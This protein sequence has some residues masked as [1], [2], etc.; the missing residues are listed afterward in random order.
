[1]ETERQDSNSSL[2][3]LY[4]EYQE[5][6]GAKGETAIARNSSTSSTSSSSSRLDS[7]HIKD[8]SDI[9]HESHSPVGKAYSL[10][11]FSMDYSSGPPRYTRTSIAKDSSTSG[12]A[13]SLNLFAS[14][15]SAISPTPTPEKSKDS[16]SSHSRHVNKSPKV[17]IQHLLDEYIPNRWNS[18]TSPRLTNIPEES[19]MPRTKTL[20]CIPR[21]PTPSV[22]LY[23]TSSA[24]C[25]FSV[26][27]EVSSMKGT[28]VNDD[29][30]TISVI[31]TVSPVS[32]RTKANTTR[33]KSPQLLEMY[34][35]SNTPRMAPLELGQPIRPLSEAAS[36]GNSSTSS[37]KS[38][39]WDEYE[40]ELPIT[41]MKKKV[42]WGGIDFGRIPFCEE[43]EPRKTLRD[44]VKF[45][46]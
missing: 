16:L 8:S 23:D 31:S 29:D 12:K 4:D 5:Q 45:R 6:K 14:D 21:E 39:I 25:A 3:S 13:Y 35:V 2:Y 32:R 30:D 27:T 40:K 28:L 38:P 10:N 17:Q 18:A 22:D 36:V 7:G 43:L 33:R 1:M 11:L 19:P 37:L 9:I 46:S 44:I 15:Y 42:H 41:P 20:P 24:S 34:I 26:L